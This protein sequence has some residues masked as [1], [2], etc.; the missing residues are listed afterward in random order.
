M[1]DGKYTVDSI[2]E[3]IVKML[4]KEDESIEEQLP[5]S[6]FPFAVQEGLILQVASDKGTVTIMPL[7]E[8]TQKR[9]SEMGK[10]M[11]ELK[12]RK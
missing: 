3:G 11:D 5:E 10:T 12:K 8:E 6:S 9:R 7:L 4:L 1:K 2:G